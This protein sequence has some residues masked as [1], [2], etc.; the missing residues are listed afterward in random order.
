M[1][2]PLLFLSNILIRPVWFPNQLDF[3]R[4]DLPLRLMFS[5]QR[6]DLLPMPGKDQAIFVNC[7]PRLYE[8][9]AAVLY[10]R[11]RFCCNALVQF[12][13]WYSVMVVLDDYLNNDY[14]MREDVKKIAIPITIMTGG[15]SE[16]FPNP[17]VQY[18]DQH[19]PRSR[20]VRFERSG[21]AL[22]LTEPLKFRRELYHFLTS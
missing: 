13:S 14:D 4:L 16:L 2:N 18:L 9:W 19:I 12:D 1:P 8:K 20:L 15:K 11:C 17:G 6:I 10:N 22:F 3:F 21:H 7:L 5:R